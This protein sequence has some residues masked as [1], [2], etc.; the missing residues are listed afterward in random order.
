MHLNTI[1]NPPD[2]DYAPKSVFYL[3]SEIHLYQIL[4][5][6]YSPN[7]ILLPIKYRQNYLLIF[8]FLT[9]MFKK[10]TNLN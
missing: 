7:K 1:L 10:L 8:N 9:Y 5:K 3:N 4:F 2:T 6:R